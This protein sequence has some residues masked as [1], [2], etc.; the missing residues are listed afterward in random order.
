M[1][2][3]LTSGNFQNYDPGNGNRIFQGLRPDVALVQ[4]MN[5]LDNSAADLRSWV[6][7]NFGPAFSYYRQSGSGIQIPNGVVSRYP[8]RASGVWDDTT[9]TNR[10]YVWARIDIPGEKD[11]WAVSVHISSGGGA[12]QRNEEAAEIKAYILAQV[13]A[14]DYLVIGGD[15]N[16]NTRTEACVSTLSA[17]VVTTGPYPADQADNSN[18]N[19]SRAK[20][21]DWVMTDT[22]LNSLKTPLVVGTI[23]YPN[24]LVFDSRVY[25][26][27]SAAAPV[28]STDSGAANMQHMAVIRAFSI[29]VNAAPTL[30]S[31]A[32]S[33]S[34]ERVTDPDSMVYEIIRAKNVGLTV[35]GADDGGEAALKYTWAAVPAGVAF[36]ANGTNAAKSTLATFPGTGN[37]TLT[38]TIQDTAG[39]SITSAVKV[40]V[41]QAAASLA[42]SPTSATLPVNATQ[43][44]AATLLDQFNNPMPGTLSYSASGGGT[45]AGTGIFTATTAGG[46]FVVTASGGGFSKTAP[47][48]VTRA[49]A[50]VS[51]GGLAKTYDGTP[52][53]VTFTT[54][55]AGLSVALLYDGSSAAPVNTGSYPVTATI[56]DPNYQGS[57][58]ATLVIS[59]DRWTVWKNANFSPSEHAAGLANDTSDP[60]ADGIPNWSRTAEAPIHA[61]FPHRSL[62]FSRTGHGR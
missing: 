3:N 40:R 31:A 59:P 42:L 21:Y 28:I 39:L 58:A 51:L 54:A 8:I 44:F 55:P 53:Y 62:A 14:A 2:G 46:P 47:V 30:A 9:M 20:P 34:T 1:A 12:S 61:R 33:A 19:A 15:F 36:S 49:A 4:E 43:S 11:L 25:S 38:A 5:Y 23:S 13:P 48:T 37:F 45:I 56:T 6:D 52:Q 7:T 57:A 26:P 24:G 32:V 50:S 17:V 60:D 35:T 10:D 22:D 18:T 16:T 27:L 41:V 29:P